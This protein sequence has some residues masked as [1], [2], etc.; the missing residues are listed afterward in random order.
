MLQFLKVYFKLGQ[1]KVFCGS[2]ITP[3]S[4]DEITTRKLTTNLSSNSSRLLYLRARL[5]K[6]MARNLQHKV[7]RPRGALNFEQKKHFLKN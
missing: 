2:E 4:E 7:F 6:S 3:D 5:N 1:S